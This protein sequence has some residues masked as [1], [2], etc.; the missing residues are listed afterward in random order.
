MTRK[1]KGSIIAKHCQRNFFFPTGPV[2]LDRYRRY[3]RATVYTYTRENFDSSLYS[4]SFNYLF[5][6]FSF[7]FLLWLH[8]PKE[9]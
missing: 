1:E 7:F 6:F 8:I 2:P 9:P 5:F 4:R 3:I